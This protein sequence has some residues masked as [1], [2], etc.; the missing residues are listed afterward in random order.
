MIPL[1][2]VIM[3]CYNG[4]KYLRE[5]IDSIYAQTYK[6]WEIIFWDN[7]SEDKSAEIAKSYDSRLKYFRAEETIHLGMARNKALEQCRGEYI[8]F[9]D[10]DDLWMPE[11]LKRQVPLFQDP[12][13]GLVFSNVVY[14]NNQSDGFRLYD[15]IEYHEGYCFSQLLENYFLCLSTIVIRG[16]VIEREDEWFD[17]R[18]NFIE[19]ADFARRIALNWKLSMTPSALAK[20]RVHDSSLTWKKGQLIIEET[21]MMITKLMG[22]IP[23][24]AAR[25]KKQIVQLRKKVCLAGSY[26][27]IRIGNSSEARKNLLNS[28]L[29]TMKGL[30]LF[31]FTFLPSKVSVFLMTKLRRMDISP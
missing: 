8:A 18:M 23:D 16:E 1:V 22:R 11:K 17:T 7:A 31:V 2:S 29:F 30:L 26:H 15:R 28:T 9:L 4:E 10:C 20:W 5:A 14:F 21:E 27:L 6:N 3:N 19:E 13:V 12:K 24:F 25:Y